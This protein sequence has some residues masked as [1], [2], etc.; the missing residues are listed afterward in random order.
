MKQN[1]ESVKLLL[2]IGHSLKEVN[3]ILGFKEN[4]LFKIMRSDIEYFNDV[5]FS[6]EV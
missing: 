6:K 4:N 3:E 2:L 5:I 1:V